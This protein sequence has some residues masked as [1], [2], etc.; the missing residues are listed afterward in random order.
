MLVSRPIVNRKMAKNGK[1]SIKMNDSGGPWK[2][3]GSVY[4]LSI[5]LGLVYLGQYMV[6]TLVGNDPALWSQML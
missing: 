4:C 6:G 5:I 1:W 2:T 3:F